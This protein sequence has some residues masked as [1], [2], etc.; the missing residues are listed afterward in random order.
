[1]EQKISIYGVEVFGL[2]CTE[3]GGC[4]HYHSP[5]DIVSIEFKCCGAY[6]CCYFCH[7]ALAGHPAQRWEMEEWDEK[8]VLCGACGAK[9]S[10]K[11][12][13]A[14][15]AHCPQCLSGFNP[16]CRNHWHFYFKML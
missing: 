8:A 15:N 5:L 6:Y 2:A 12:Y 14:C 4:Q 10:I 16:G 1:M 7:E 3:R 13:L 11:E 9:L